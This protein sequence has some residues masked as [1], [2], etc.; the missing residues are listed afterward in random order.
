MQ[1]QNLCEML[2]AV[3]EVKYHC[4][5]CICYNYLRQ[6]CLSVCASAC[7]SLFPSGKTF[8]MF[9]TEIFHYSSVGNIEI[10]LIPKINIKHFTCFLVLLRWERP[11]G[12]YTAKIFA[13]N[14]IKT[15][16]GIL[17]FRLKMQWL[18]PVRACVRDSLLL[19][20]NLYQQSSNDN[21]VAQKMERA[22]IF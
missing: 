14:L 1:L 19:V 15:R 5:L 2:G 11:L 18:Y 9:Y 4:L 3:R 8:V 7:I 16:R 12:K 10:V 22:A 6:C 13:E 20:F 21:S 17:F